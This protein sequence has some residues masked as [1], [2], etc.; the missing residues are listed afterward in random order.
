MTIIIKNKTIPLQMVYTRAHTHT[1][2]RPCYFSR[3]FLRYFFRALFLYFSRWKY[4]YATYSLLLLAIIMLVFFL[5]LCVCCCQRSDCSLLENNQKTEVIKKKLQY[6]VCDACTQV[7]MDSFLAWYHSFVRF[8]L[9]FFL[10]V[11]FWFLFLV[12]FFCS[13]SRKPCAWHK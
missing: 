4:N 1:H 2:T 3:I 6:I 10:F 13:Y 8:Y 7:H 5:S 9:L 11:S 12:T